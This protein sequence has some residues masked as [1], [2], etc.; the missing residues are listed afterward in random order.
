MTSPKEPKFLVIG[1]GLPR[2]GTLSFMHALEMI[3]PG[4]CHHMMKA[5]NFGDEWS[6]IF[7]NKMS[8]EQFKNFFLSNGEVA[9]VDAPFCFYYER[10]MQVWPDA[11]VILTVREPEGWVKSVKSTILKRRLVDPTMIFALLG[12][13]PTYLGDP[14][15]PQPKWPVKMFMNFRKHC[16]R[17]NDFENAVRSNKGVEFFHQW[18]AEVEA[19]VPKDRLLT[20]N[21]R[22]GWAPLCE[23]LGVP[24]PD[25]PFPRVNSSNEFE[26]ARGLVYRRSWLLVYELLTLPLW[27][28]VLHKVV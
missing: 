21:V 19:T 5:L 11:K 15:N 2:T 24:T 6:D 9:A 22:E 8:D 1:A 20:F 4:K 13:F 3:L 7:T 10:A 17:M 26:D 14:R 25:A 18:T 16:S 27:A 28:Y 23:F 12:L